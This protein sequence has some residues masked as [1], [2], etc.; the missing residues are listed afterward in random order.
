MKLRSGIKPFRA[1]ILAVCPILIACGLLLA[2]YDLQI[3]DSAAYAKEDRNTVTRVETV[4]AARGE[5]LD[6]YGRPLVSN[7]VSYDISIE[8]SVLVT[9]PNP[10]GILLELID[11]TNAAGLPYTDTLP[12]T[13]D[14]PLR[15]YGDELH[16][17]GPPGG[18]PRP[19]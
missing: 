6:R 8:R 9:D 5:I 4:P 11:L 1:V 18:L 12:V 7:A 15:L 16:P 2:L 10:N 3:M 13:D 19:L 17:A 14:A